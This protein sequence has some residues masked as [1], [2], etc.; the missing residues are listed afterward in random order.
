MLIQPWRSTA[1]RF[2]PTSSK[3]GGRSPGDD[4]FGH[5]AGRSFTGSRPAAGPAG[6]TGDAVGRPA[7][8]LP[9]AQMPRRQGLRPLKRWCY[10]GLYGPELMLCA[11]VADVGPLGQSF[12]ALWDRRA[13][14]LDTETV[15]L[16]RRRITV[17][18]KEVAVRSGTARLELAVSP[19]GEPVEVVSPHG[20]SYIWTRKTPVQAHG[21]LTLG[22]EVRPI[23]GVGLLDES[24]GYHARE[25]AWEWSAGVGTSIDGWPVVWNLVRGVHDA[26]TMSER[27]VW[28]Q[29]R[30]VEVPPVRFSADLDEIWGQDGSLLHFDEEATRMRIENLALIRSEYVQPFGHFSGTLPGGVELS[31]HEPAFGVMERHRARW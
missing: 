2:A 29:G 13:A 10:V 1:S 17:T 9:P 15:L 31:D 23:R 4:P 5:P 25:T 12:W 16:A 6:P 24:A 11:G 30:P 8:A 27:T 3:G 26:D 18:P 19:V 20:R 28:V 14:V 21:H 7:V 22:M